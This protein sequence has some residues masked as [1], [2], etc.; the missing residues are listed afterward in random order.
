MAKLYFKVGSDWEEVV[1]LRNEIAKLKQELMSMDGT[2]SPA[3]FKALNA[4]LAASNQR[5]D[6]LV[7]NAAKAG[8]EMETG[9][10]KGIYDGE[11][12]VNSLSE[13]IIK[14]KDIIR[15]TQNDVSMLTEQYKKLGKYNPKRQ[16]LSDELNR[17]KAALGEQKYA[18]GELQSQQALARLSTKA[19]KDEYALFKDESK[20]VVTVNE[21]VGVSFKKTLAAIGGIAMLKQVASNVVSTAGMFQKYESVLT[22]ALNGSSEKAK[23]YLSDINSFAAKTNF[24]LDELTDD[25]IKFV[26]R[27]VTPSMDA[28]K[29]MG[30]FTNTVAKPFDQLTEAILDINNPERWKEF[31]VR[32]QTEGNKVKLSFRDMTVECDRTVES[33]M[34]AVEQ[35]GSMKGVEGSTEAIAKTIEGQ[36]SNLED[37][38]TTALAEIGLANQDLIS[39]SISAVDTIVK[40]YDIIGKSVLAL[41][42]IYGVYRA[43][44]LINTIVEQGSV[45]SIWAKITATKAATVAQVAYNKVLAMNPYV[46]VGMAVVSLGVAVYTLAEHTTYAEK[47]ARSA[48]ESMEKMKNASENLKNKINE[49]LSVI[50]DETSTQYQKA[51]AYLKLQRILPEVFKNMDIE[52]IKLMDQ[53]SLLKQ[54]NKA[55]DRREIVGAK[56]GV[57]LAQKEVD[58]I[59]ALIA[60]DSKRGTY[61]GQYEIQLSD[62]KSKLEAAKKVVADIE[63]IQ[64]EANKQKGKDDKKVVIKNKEFWTNRK[65]EAETALNSIASSQKKLLDAGKFKGIDDAVVN[66]YKDNVR[67]LKEAEKELKVYDSF[68]K[69]GSQAQK[70]AAK[71]LKQQEQL[72]EQLLSIRRKNQQDEI[73]LM[74]DGTEK[75]L[76]QIDLDYQKELD[77]IDKQRKEWEKA[78]NGKLTDEQ[79]SDLSA[80]EE[81]AYKSYGKGVK[82][83][84][85]EKLESER[86]AWQE[87]FIEYGNYQEK[88]KNLVQ[89]YN[90]EIAKLQTDS[91]EYASKVAQKNKALEQ[92]DE[93]FGHSTKA[94]ADLFEDAGN[95]SVSAIQ[96][97][98]DKYEILIKYMSGTDKDISIAD[99]KGIGF[100]DKDIERIEKGEIS[101][102][103]VTDAIKGLKDELKGKSP[104]QAFVSDLKKG[105]E[106]IKKGGNDSKKISQGITDVG[107]TVT[108]FAPALNEFG[109][110]I[111]D[112]FGFDDSKITSAIDALGGLGQTASGFGQIM[113]GDIVGGAMSAVSGISSVVSALDGMFGADYS[114]YNEMVE[115]Y[116]KLN[117]IWDELI[118]K[119]LEYIG[120]SY[121]MEADKVGEEALGLVE[122]Q[123]EA[124]RLLG[125]ERLNS[126]A[127]AGS[128]SIGKRMAKNT[129]SSDWQDIADAL[130]MSVNAAKELI[131][132]GRMTGLF[133]LTVEQLEKL[134]SEAP[135]FWAKMD[136]DVQ[137]YLNGII[138]G[139]ERIEDIQDQIKEQLTQTTF[140]GVFDSFVDTLMDMDS[141]AKDFS[142]SF[143]GYMQRAVLTTMVGNKFTE[144]LQTWYDA[145]AQAN[146]DQG[147]ITKEE[148]E[149]LRKQYDA[150]AGSAL[151]ERDKLAEIFGWKKE[152]TDSS[153]DNYEDFIGSLQSSL[154]SLDVTAKDV[155]DNIYDY[156]RQAMINALYEKEYKSKME[157]LYKTFEGL[158]KD[159]LSESDM[160]QLGSRIDQYIE[161]MMKGVEDVNGLFADKLKN[162]EDLQSFVDSV[163]SAMS[164]V[165]ATAEDVTDNIFEYIRQQMVDKMFTDSFQ[166]QIEELYKKVQEAMSDGDITDAE[167]DALRNEAEKLA[168]DITAAK[169]ILSD[170]LGITESNLKKELEEEFKSF[171]DGILSSLYDTEVTAETVAKNISDSMRK[172]L[173]EAMYLEQ[174]EPRIKAIWEKWKEYS[175]DGLVTDEERTNIKND[176]DGL[177]KEVADA[178][179]EISD[180]WK[181]SGEEV[182]KAFTSFSDSIKSVL[183]DTE[184]T[185]EDIADNI[186]QY[187]RNA[188]VDSMF[189]AQLQPQIQAW[190]DKYT[191]FM[192]DGAIDTA[193]RKTLDEMIA[194]I[195]K[196]GVDI[197][198]AA[199]KLFPTLDTGAINRAE[200]AAQEAENARN[201][202]EQEW[203][204]F[205][206]G[207]LNSLYDIEATAEDISDDMSEYM[208]KALIK[209][210]YVENFKPQMQ[211]WYNEWKKAMGDDDLTSEEKQLLDSMK[212]TM[213][214]DM[215]KEV[216]AINQFFG[217]MFLQQA[218]SK[219]FEA[220]S[221]DTGEELNGRFTALQVAG[222][223]IK[224][225]SIQQTGLLSSING[226][227]SLLNLRSG[228]V[229]ALLSGTP[230][231]ADRAKETIASGYQSQVHIV[232]PTED[233][234]ALTD[235]VSNM[236]R[237]VDEMRTFQVEGNMDRRDILENSVILAKNS[238][239]ILDNTNDIKQD[240]KNL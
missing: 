216:D 23:A 232:F 220:M 122:K 46:A 234:K 56:T 116:N 100:T 197:V 98:I 156:F 132:T 213:V 171:S 229:P 9:F 7:T 160:V 29:K 65:K 78:Q 17:A 12:A 14:Q 68:S 211:K 146:K 90:D 210:M 167:K 221:Q 145:F 60:A 218:S 204:S 81:N 52:K 205:S 22:N 124:Y 130:D 196:A 215:K 112:I 107:N 187:M 214:D 26:N 101:I 48:A 19:L 123:I 175:E 165:E 162:A 91:P 155:S 80:W 109:S 153:T 105:I 40:N 13:E 150:I 96:S 158:S 38:I 135:A 2:Q 186:Y 141:S 137:E 74:E 84:S 168:N 4:Q 114:H 230:N 64:T 195:Q 3:A 219:G 136:G 10:K 69:Q 134:K 16:S 27:G 106:A 35:F 63:K 169:D 37:T 33:V 236:E 233:I 54:I 11:K 224:N 199:N 113:S 128:H 177:S 147:G 228:D 174:Y 151:A 161:Q 67:K 24:Q 95:K 5:L 149:A 89:K 235:K 190:Y 143:S 140:D 50:R 108:S 111:A 144:D 125:K 39:G 43:G 226:K 142:D 36:M 180:A 194:E 133:D 72:A 131:G 49:L 121:G 198:D 138:D 102:K 237:I 191:E 20:A 99:L 179:G 110:S 45:K 75:K 97:I 129:S 207:I 32:V 62:A 83:A 119:K 203:E 57:V 87:Y 53:L 21:G 126:G 172:E 170:T 76:A 181:D 192:K 182:R 222:E 44:L 178:A 115:E 152:D 73:N 208:R 206:D 189:T 200:E 104:W 173:I 183:Y 15:E 227:L 201:E 148:M 157:E 1:R 30:D 42:E 94:M 225:Q 164:S 193:E 92:L 58:K 103:D 82:D 209:A 41:I 117:E 6:E 85:K 127:S 79:E 223:E 25:F 70:E 120:I 166:P 66:S 139:E 154:T 118:D 77:A 55:A 217:T 34:K 18:L 239:R 159:G 176:I 238:P 93:Q 31:G 88:R 212:Q 185:A 51:D 184:A 86:K 61:S 188:L 59:N 8:A 202:A 163:K 240:I 28:M 47:T 231:F 71:Q